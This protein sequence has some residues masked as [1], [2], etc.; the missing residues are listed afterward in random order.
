MLFAICCAT[1]NYSDSKWKDINY[2]LSIGNALPEYRLHGG[3]VGHLNKLCVPERKTK[4]VCSHYHSFGHRG[5]EVGKH[6]GNAM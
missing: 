5:G 3:G 4:S 1:G 2:E 6:R